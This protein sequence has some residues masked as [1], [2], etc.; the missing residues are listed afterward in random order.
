MFNYGNLS[1]V[2][3]EELCRDIMERKLQ[4]H[5]HTYTRGRDEGLDIC[6]KP[7]NPKVMI[8][9]KHYFNFGSD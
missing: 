4:T 9:V 6:D 8:Q 7:I 2:E 1:D 3:F 5:L